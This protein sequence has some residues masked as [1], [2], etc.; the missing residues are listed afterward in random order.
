[1]YLRVHGTI[2]VS[3]PE[4]RFLV[5]RYFSVIAI[6]GLFC[7][8]EVSMPNWCCNN[9]Q[10]LSGWYSG[11]CDSLIPVLLQRVLALLPRDTK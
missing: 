6:L 5:S 3:E 8:Y 11:T 7:V 2:K 4:H 1:M 10:K 9:L